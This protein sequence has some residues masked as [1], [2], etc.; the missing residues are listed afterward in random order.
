MVSPCDLKQ[1]KDAVSELR[2]TSPES[3][4]ADLVE[5]KIR[6]M[7]TACPGALPDGSPARDRRILN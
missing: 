6:A 5:E 2:A 1:V 3:A 4:L 7:E